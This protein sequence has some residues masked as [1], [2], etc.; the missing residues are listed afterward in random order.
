V[1]SVIV[2]SHCERAELQF[3]ARWMPHASARAEAWENLIDLPKRK[4]KSHMQAAMERSAGV[5]CAERVVER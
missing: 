5:A 2:A 1:F 3:S 4:Q